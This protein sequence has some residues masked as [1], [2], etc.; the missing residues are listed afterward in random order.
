M[1][2]LEDVPER[3]RKMVKKQKKM[4]KMVAKALVALERTKRHKLAQLTV[5]VRPVLLALEIVERAPSF[6]E[7][8]N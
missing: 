6:L 2:W 7:K 3:E 4:L 5:F 8:G 1:L